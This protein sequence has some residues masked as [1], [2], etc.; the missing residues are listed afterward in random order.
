VSVKRGANSAAPLAP[1]ELNEQKN[2]LLGKVTGLKKELQD[3]RSKLDSQVKTYRTVGGLGLVCE[4]ASPAS[5]PSRRF[6]PA[7]LTVAAGDNRPAQDTYRRGRVLARGIHGAEGSAEAAA[8][9]VHMLF[10]LILGHTRCQVGHQ[11]AEAKRQ[12]CTVLLLCTQSSRLGLGQW[13]KV[14]MLACAQHRAAM[15]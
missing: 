8:R 9:W 3:W 12:L 7:C 11:S 10:F 2:E 6:K 15:C 1:Q 4:P 5:A 14:Q 13:W